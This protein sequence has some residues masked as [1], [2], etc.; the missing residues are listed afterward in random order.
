MFVYRSDGYAARDVALT[1]SYM[2]EGRTMKR[3]RWIL[4]LAGLLSA[5]AAVA[6]FTAAP[7]SAPAFAQ[8]LAPQECVCSAGVNLG[9]RS[10]GS[11]LL[12]NCQCGA[13]QCVV[14]VGSG[15]LECG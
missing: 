11:S 7:T 14:H 4:T 10:Q 6:I 5:V 12:K 15:D 13:L 3:T 9:A 2:M 1:F 8:S